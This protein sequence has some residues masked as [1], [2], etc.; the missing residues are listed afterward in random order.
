MTDDGPVLDPRVEQGFVEPFVVVAGVLR[1]RDRVDRL[2]H[3]VGL[4]EHEA[5]Q[6][7]ECLLAIPRAATWTAEA[8]H[9]V[10]EA[11]ELVAC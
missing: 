2:E 7:L 11:L 5:A 1:S 9:D 8:R 6:R 4:L 10:D 3:L